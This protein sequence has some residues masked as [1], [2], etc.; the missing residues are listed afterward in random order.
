MLDVE[1][2]VETLL[3]GVRSGRAALVEIKIT[4]RLRAMLDQLEAATDTIKAYRGPEPDDRRASKETHHAPWR[5]SAP[6]PGSWTWAR[7]DVNSQIN[8]PSFYKLAETLTK[9]SIALKSLQPDTVRYGL[10]RTLF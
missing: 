4:D 7:P 9:G 6:A 1:A 2:H 8:S 5:S 3:A 10:S